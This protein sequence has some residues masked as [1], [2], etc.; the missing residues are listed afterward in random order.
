MLWS[1]LLTD[2]SGAGGQFHSRWA[3]GGRHWLFRSLPASPT[4]SPGQ[5]PHPCR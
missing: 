5:S 1:L 2:G 4:H 3:L